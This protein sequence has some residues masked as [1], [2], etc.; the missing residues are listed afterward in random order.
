MK[1]RLKLNNGNISRLRLIIQ[2]LAF[3]LLVYGGYLF[4]HIGSSVPTF[5][6]PYNNGCPGSCYL[7]S[8]QHQAHITWA[9]MIGFRG[10]ALLKG[11]AVFVL[12]FIIINKSWC[13][14][15]CP[16]GTIQ[17]W[18]T[19]L[20]SAMGIRYTRFDRM[21]F[22]WFSRSKYLFLILLILI[23]LGISNSL[24]WLPHFS[25]DL[26]APFCQICPGR[27]IIPLFTLDGSQL[28]ID[29][30]SPA[31][32]TMSTLGIVF[33]AF[34]FVGAFFKKRFFCLICPMS[35]I[36]NIF[37]RIGLLQ[38]KK[39]GSACTK[40]GNCYRVCDIGIREIAEDIT[41]KNIIKDDCMMCFKCVES[42]P[43]KDALKIKFLGI[44]IFR[45]TPEGFFARF[46]LRHK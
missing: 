24:F 33:T 9:D 16:L 19:K 12:L 36:E 8:L 44:T 43:E 15:I 41:S 1:K 17:D 29:T 14:F 32:T 30:S 34:F 40:C 3:F 23:P 2:L 21:Q 27:T 6:C 25:H 26:A 13:G 7:I 38:L 45:S 28:V 11:L 42:C 4:I 31:L 35:A 10:L 5:A 22:K 46:K 18:I 20:R 39:H 37:K